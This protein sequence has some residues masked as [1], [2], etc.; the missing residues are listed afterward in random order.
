LSGRY[1]RCRRTSPNDT[2]DQQRVALAPFAGQPV[3]EVLTVTLND[4][5]T[6]TTEGKTAILTSL[7]TGL[8]NNGV[9]PIT[10]RLQLPEATG[11]E[12]NPSFS[13]QLPG[14]SGSVPSRHFEG[15]GARLLV[16]TAE[17]DPDDVALKPSTTTSVSAPQSEQRTLRP[18]R[19]DMP[20]DG[21]YQR[22]LPANWNPPDGL[23]FVA[24]H[25]PALAARCRR[26]PV[27]GSRLRSAVNS[28][29]R[30]VGVA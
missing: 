19:R 2:D 4:P 29:R 28:A 12:T 15:K 5:P 17:R 14:A 6:E 30:A 16:T 27:G 3:N 7:A 22:S 25:A 10:V 18:P 21:V 8:S 23:R 9:P 1:C 20:I 13:K 24:P 26:A 11:Q